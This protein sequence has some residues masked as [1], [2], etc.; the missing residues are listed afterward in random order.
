MVRRLRGIRHGRGTP[1]TS[2]GSTRFAATLDTT[3]PARQLFGKTWTE[4][5]VEAWNQYPGRRR[6]ARL[7]PI[8]F[9]VDGP[10]SSRACLVW[11][12]EGEVGIAGGADVPTVSGSTSAWGRF[13]GGQVSASRSLQTPELRFDGP[14]SRIAKYSLAFN[15]LAKVVAAMGGPRSDPRG[16]GDGGSSVL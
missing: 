4:Q 6:L 12:D 11:N 9:S 16:Q 15:D 5:F 2:S 14:L 3:D 13:I 7:G 8:C 1:S 10:P